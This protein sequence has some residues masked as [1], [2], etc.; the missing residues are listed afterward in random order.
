MDIP[1][2]KVQM[3][4]RHNWKAW[5]KQWDKLSVRFR[6]STIDFLSI[7]IDI[8]RKFY[9]FTILNFTIKNR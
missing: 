8:S 6:I 9:M 1:G 4:Y 2:K 7:E 3:K 5:N